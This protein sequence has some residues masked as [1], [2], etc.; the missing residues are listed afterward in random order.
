MTLRDLPEIIYYK[1]ILGLVM[2][3]ELSDDL[4]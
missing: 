4:T 3:G 2:L 1:Q